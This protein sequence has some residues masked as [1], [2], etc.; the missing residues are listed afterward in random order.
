M[1]DIEHID[2]FADTNTANDSEEELE[3]EF[4]TEEHGETRPIVVINYQHKPGV[5]THYCC[6]IDRDIHTEGTVISIINAQKTSDN[7]GSSYITYTVRVG[8]CNHSYCCYYTDI[9]K[10]LY[11][12]SVQKNFII[13]FINKLFWTIGTGG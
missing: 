9:S 6:Q 8:V 13:N 12:L 5:K 2:P 3:Q 11:N 4:E 7:S 1:S 10:D